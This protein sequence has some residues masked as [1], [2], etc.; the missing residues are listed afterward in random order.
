MPCEMPA[1]SAHAAEMWRN[2]AM[3]EAEALVGGQPTHA[4]LDYL[5]RN[6]GSGD[7]VELAGQQV[8]RL[9]ASRP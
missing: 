7:L 1:R 5:L 3:S 8:A 6:V 4:L 9:S 2:A